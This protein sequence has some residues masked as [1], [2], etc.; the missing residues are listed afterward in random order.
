MNAPMVS[1]M[2]KPVD[3]V[4]VVMLIVLSVMLMSV[5]SANQATSI[6]ENVLQNV[7]LVPIEPPVYVMI[8]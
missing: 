3:N 4:L 7:L 5:I 1:T 8:V 2:T 6:M